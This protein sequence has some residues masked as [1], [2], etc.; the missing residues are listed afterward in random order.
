MHESLLSNDDEIVG[1]DGTETDE[2]CT[3]AEQL[4]AEESQSLDGHKRKSVNP[5]SK[6]I[7]KRKH[8]EKTLSAAQRDAL[9]LTEAKE[10]SEFQ[11]DLAD[12]THETMSCF[13]NAL[14]D[15]SSSM[16]QVGNGLSQLI[17]MMAQAV[18]A[19]W[20]SG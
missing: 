8:L 1:L 13:S 15:I 5:V 14:T 16:A 18:M 7:D 11:K 2:I 9:L 19:P 3:A 20:R 17:E 10:E 12:A 4:S 6:L